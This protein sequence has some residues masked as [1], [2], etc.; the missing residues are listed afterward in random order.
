MPAVA[1]AASRDQIVG[2][3]EQVETPDSVLEQLQAQGGDTSLPNLPNLP[4]LPPHPLPGTHSPLDPDDGISLSSI[5]N[6]GKQVWAIIEENQPVVNLTYDFA[7]AL[8]RGVESAADLSGFTDLQFQSYHIYGT[9]GFGQT[10]YDVTYTLV[11]QHSGSV[12][13]K[14]HYL[15]SV[16]IIPSDVDV[17]WGYNLDMKVANVATTNVGSAEAPVASINMEVSF[18]VHTKVQHHATSTIYQI[19]GDGA[20]IK[21]TQL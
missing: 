1:Q 6:L 9:N 18:I 11:Y 16:G 10:V 5:V 3:V 14:G 20:P 12:N 17:K 15:A 8:P 19:R 7:N 2:H 13:G 4:K 21:S